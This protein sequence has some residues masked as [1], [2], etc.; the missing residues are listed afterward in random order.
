MMLPLATASILP[1]DCSL[2]PVNYTECQNIISDTSLSLTEKQDL[3]LNLLNPQTDLPNYDFIWNWNNQITFSNPPET[4]T[5]TSSGTIQNTWLKIVG[6]NKSV[7]DLNQQKWFVEPNG[8]IQVA[9]HYDLQLPSATLPGECQ[10]TYSHAIQNDQ[11]TVFANNQISGNSNVTSYNFDLPDQ[12]DLNFRAV[13]NIADKLTTN[14]YQSQRH[15]FF[16]GWNWSCWY[17]CDFINSTVDNYSVNLEDRLP[18]TV[19]KPEFQIQT[20]IDPKNP[21]PKI[22]LN[23]ESNELLNEVSLEQN[24]KNF[25]TSAARYD[26]NTSLPPYGSLFAIRI[27]EQKIKSNF[28]ILDQNQNK[29]VLSTDS[30][31]DCQLTVATD[32]EETSQ[33]CNATQLKKTR[34]ELSTDQNQFDTNQTIQVQAKLV[35]D[36][37][38]VLPGKTLEFSSKNTVE[39][40]STNENGVANW[41]IP[42]NESNGVIFANFMADAGLASSQNTLRVAVSDSDLTPKAYNVTVF[43]LAYFVLFSLAKRK[44]GVF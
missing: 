36:Q 26:L 44:L 12:S 2:A 22:Y 19:L 18:A 37:N 4:I 29:F 16:N 1:T 23:V 38:Q 25:S 34:I 24:G 27:P 15:C 11:L 14:H 6:I 8:Q 3:Y 28:L 20:A 40:V 35:D 33:S 41:S 31:N 39:N 5:P 43:F 7:Y 42:A 21:N 17:Q 13:W 30:T 32:F 9:K 10:T